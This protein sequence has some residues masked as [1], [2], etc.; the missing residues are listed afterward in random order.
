MPGMLKD[1]RFWFGV[2]IGY[3]LLSFIPALS[4]SG[5]VRGRAKTGG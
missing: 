4:V 5:M 3:L 2:L 1:G